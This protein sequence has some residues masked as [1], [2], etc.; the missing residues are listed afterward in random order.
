MYFYPYHWTERGLMDSEDVQAC[1][2]NVMD[3]MGVSRKTELESSPDSTM[4]KT[5]N[6]PS[7]PFESS[8][9]TS[10]R[11]G[12]LSASPDS[13]GISSLSEREARGSPYVNTDHYL[14]EHSSVGNSHASISAQQD[15]LTIV[16]SNMNETFIN[17]P[18]NRSP[19]SQDKSLSHARHGPTGPE[20]D[21]SFSQHGEQDDKKEEIASNSAG[22]EGKL[23]SSDASCCRCSENEHISLSSGEMVVRSHISCLED[24]SLVIFSSMEDSS[25]SDTAGTMSM[26]LE[27]IMPDVSKASTEQETKE[28]MGHPSLG[29]TFIQTNSLENLT[30][31]INTSAI[32]SHVPL[33]SEGGLFLTFICETPTDQ[34]NQV[35]SSGADAELLPQVTEEFSSE[36]GKTFGSAVSGVQNS[37]SVPDTS[38][39]VQCI[40]SKMP[41]LSYI[42]PFNEN[43]NSPSLQLEKKKQ[44]FVTSKERPV[45]GITPSI[46]KVKKTEL[47]NVPK[48]N[49]DTLKFKDLTRIAQ[50]AA[51]PGTDKLQKIV[52]VKKN[53]EVNK[54][55]TFRFTTA[56]VTGRNTGASATSKTFHPIGQ[57]E[58]A[59]TS[60]LSGKSSHGNDAVS[61]PD[62]HLAVQ[63]CD[64]VVQCSE[65]NFEGMPATTS[66]VSKESAQ[67]ADG[68][69]STSAAEILSSSRRQV[70]PKPTPKKGV[71][72]KIGVG[73]GSAAGQDRIWGRRYSE[74]LPK[75][76]KATQGAAA[77]RDDG[78]KNST[79]AGNPKCPSQLKHIEEANS[80]ANNS[81]GVN[82]IS[83]VAEA[84][85]SAGAQLN[86]N[87]S[88]CQDL[89]SLSQDRGGALLPQPPGASPRLTPLSARSKRGAPGAIESRIT[90]TVGKAQ[91]STGSEGSHKAVETEETSTGMKLHQNAPKPPQTPGRSAFMGPPLV[92]VRPPRKIPVLNQDSKNTPVSRGAAQ[93]STPFKSSLLKAKLIST[94]SKNNGSATL[95]ASST[96]K[97]PSSSTGTPLKKTNYGRLVE[98]T[99]CGTVDKNKSKAVSRQHQQQPSQRAKVSTSRTAAQD[100]KRER[101]IHQL[102]GF[103]TDSN[104]RFQ[105][106]AIV[107][108]Q[109]LAQR[110]DA[111]TQCRKLSQELVSL[112][113]ELACSV[114]SS[115]CLEREKEALRTALLDATRRLQE[116]HQQELA[117]LEQKLQAVH[118]AEWDHVHLNYQE[119]ANK[120]KTLMQQQMEELKA[121]QEAMKVQLESSH[122]EQLQSVRQQYELS[123]EELRRVHTQE[124]QSLE[125]ELKD[126]EAA[127]SAQIEE[128]TVENNALLEKLAAEKIRRREL[129]ENTQKDSHTLY[130]EQEL[131]SLKVVLEIKN[132]QLHKQEKK[133]MDIGKLADKKVQLDEMLIKVQQENEDLKARMERHAAL[134][135][136][137][138]TEQALLQ[139]S[140]QKESKVNKRLSMENE[141][142]LWKL[143]NGDVGSPRKLSPSPTSPS[144]PFKLQ[145]PRASG[146][147]SSPPVSPR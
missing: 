62:L 18:V 36:L 13:G 66:Q 132:K 24:Q 35:K 82:K 121:N 139:E 43:V 25:I 135:R 93:K 103:L 141:E 27:S 54:R 21:E 84:R 146:F 29:V 3:Y 129:V 72:N 79:K 15:F 116:E 123:L 113:G 71:A 124:L 115:E 74:G 85:K 89:G 17:A 75:D 99:Y 140:L 59:T 147:F 110:D 73:S 34:T 80:P 51:V 127:L 109:T 90:R 58:K 40:A 8:A 60:G 142:L 81:R 53:G 26:P 98:H 47:Q 37:D 100:E 87:K 28:S 14:N 16:T 130:L 144:N 119:E 22:G 134:S 122:A 131:E 33:P 104:C 23:S 67:H 69:S 44:I 111:T 97:G 39:P 42:S 94:P 41:N 108:Q 125:Q 86:E 101:I 12:Q 61:S 92:P 68:L 96:N 143:H 78:G 117:D 45:A 70:D 52:Q 112:K 105:A 7:D 48:S 95:T 76:K 64:L 107:L 31:E 55:N 50:Q 88:R 133:L 9:E 11:D 118:K 91:I 10:P 56:K 2:T 65:N 83:L 6:L 128:L 5:F 30:E 106:L 49:I 4:A 145:S 1:S 137:L 138:S 120:Y 20:T 102:K 38:T 63:E 57:V 126:S 77:S 114:H 136:Q 19:N 46:C 32:S